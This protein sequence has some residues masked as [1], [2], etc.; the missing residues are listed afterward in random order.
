MVIRAQRLP[1][2][3]IGSLFDY[4]VNLK[5]SQQALTTSVRR[6]WMVLRLSGSTIFMMNFNQPFRHHYCTIIGPFSRWYQYDI[7]QLECPGQEEIFKLTHTIWYYLGLRCYTWRSLVLCSAQHQK[8]KTKET[9][10][11]VRAQLLGKGELLRVRYTS[12]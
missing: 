7:P 2:H 6:T 3:L 12:A 5:L 8:Q 11:K 9:Q 1:G 10:R 4:P